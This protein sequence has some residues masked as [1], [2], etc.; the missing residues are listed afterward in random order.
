MPFS[1]RILASHGQACPYCEQQMRISSAGRR[2]HYAKNPHHVV[3]KAHNNPDFPTR[4]HVIPR[5]VMPAQGT[6]IVCRKC[7][8]EKRNRTIAEWYIE[9]RDNMDPRARVVLQF[10]QA[11]RHLCLHPTERLSDLLNVTVAEAPSSAIEATPA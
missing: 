7:N 11:N 3:A 10:M 6:I 1:H 4:D 9:L 5:S 2:A 8:L